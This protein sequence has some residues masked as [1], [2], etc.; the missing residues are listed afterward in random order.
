[1]I[2]RVHHAVRRVFE[3]N[4]ERTDGIQVSRWIRNS[5]YG[6]GIAR[7]E[8]NQYS[9][10]VCRQGSPAPMESLLIVSLWS[11]ASANDTI[12]GSFRALPLL[13]TAR[14]EMNLESTLS[15]E[16][17]IPNENDRRAPLT[18]IFLLNTR[19]FKLGPREDARALHLFLSLF[20]LYIT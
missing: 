8:R 7:T 13:S 3:S 16:C 19:R 2:R 5:G 4:P 9:K 14:Y 10:I 11:S 1:M 18:R 17:W 12:R 6:V 15:Q 20:C